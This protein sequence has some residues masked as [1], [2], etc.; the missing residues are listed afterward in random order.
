[1][2]IMNE[3]QNSFWEIYS[4]P[5]LR[6]IYQQIH[7]SNKINESD[8]HSDGKSMQQN[9]SLQK[10]NTHGNSGI[11][12]KPPVT[13]ACE[14]SVKLSRGAGAT[15]SFA[16]TVSKVQI[17]ASM[18]A[19]MKP[20]QLEAVEFI[21]SRLTSSTL[22]CTTDEPST[23]V[24]LA[25]DVGTGK[26]LVGLVSVYTLTRYYNSKAVIVCPSSLVLNWKNEMKKFLPISFLNA[27]IFL[28]GNAHAD[29]L[30]YNFVHSS[31]ES[32]P[33]L[34]LSYEL[35]RTFS[36]ALN[37]ISSFNCILCDEGHRIKNAYGTKTTSALAN[38]IAVRRIVLTGTP[39]QNN[40]DELY[41]IVNFV[42]PFYLGTLK[43]FREEFVLHIKSKAEDP[44]RAEMKLS[45]LRA[46]LSKMLL[47]R[48]RDSILK[49]ELPSRTDLIIH[50]IPSEH[51]RLT[52]IRV[53]DS[54]LRDDSEV[55]RG[56]LPMLMRLRLLCSSPE[57]TA[58]ATTASRAPD[59]V[60]MDPVTS[61]KL[62]VLMQ[63]LETVMRMPTREKVVV[64]SNFTIVLDEVAVLVRRQ[65]WSAF[66]IDGSVALDKRDRIVQA[67]NNPANAI[68]ILL[69]SAKAGGVGLTL[70][71]ASRIVLVEPDW[72]PATDAQCMGRVWRQGQT[73]PVFVY[74]LLTVGTIE[75][76]ILQRQSLKNELACLI[77]EEA[78]VN[79]VD[80]AG[81]DDAD[82]VNA[83]ALS[84]SEV[85]SLALP[86][87]P[88]DL[89]RH[90]EDLLRRQ[91]IEHG[92]DAVADRVIAGKDAIIEMVC[93]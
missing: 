6:L 16:R 1:L 48:S 81:G 36:E 49:R 3:I 73:K 45:E 67:F 93:S 21:I 59:C 46:R 75:E 80:D 20:H 10:E 12:R 47:R 44:L 34:V 4:Q 87:G 28:Q 88:D 90:M 79:V 77:D 56:V 70:T 38:C 78:V 24:I 89:T 9:N 14:V 91:G 62:R 29:K 50:C 74:R 39:I 71:G 53:I 64:V 7:M 92:V 76:S 23:G 8:L 85:R 69:L 22:A 54:E 65:H 57:P 32:R 2:N 17:E 84:V 30:V 11:K 35:F 55:G 72:N 68:N 13:N 58:N 66:R 86:R 19:M 52:Y 15:N 40:L 83:G 82:V 31:P 41:S 26:T 18:L 27:T 5:I 61:S 25:D 60:K 42:C 37:T 51:Q 33:L 63:M 43:E